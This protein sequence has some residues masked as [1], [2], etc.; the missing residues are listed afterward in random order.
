MAVTD[1]AINGIKQMILSGQVR[2]G[3]KL[4]K[5]TE[6]ATRL[7]LSRSSLR[8]AVRALIMAGVL[9]TRQGDGTYV[10]SL[11]PHQLLETMSLAV[12]FMRNRAL[13]ELFEVR[14]L[15]EPAATALATARMTPE[16][17]SRLRDSL[18]RMDAAESVEELVESDDEFH[19]EI[20][21][22]TGNAALAAFLQNLYGRTMRA[23]IWRGLAEEDAIQRTKVS[24]H[25]I[26][27]A[28]ANRDS[29]LA[30]AAATMHIA[31][32]E[33]W[34]RRLPEAQDGPPTIGVNGSDH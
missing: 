26:Y 31:E 20:S 14:R 2:P 28:I 9:K 6:L 17:L 33:A 4:P 32:V 15:I 11:E 22:A 3:E 23:R 16:G 1:E 27:D 25:A 30:R 10:T 19:G 24:H 18:R 13:V 5:E 8:E 34:F 21:T 7:G 12:D 29:E